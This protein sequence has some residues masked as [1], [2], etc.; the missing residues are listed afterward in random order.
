MKHHIVLVMELCE[1][2][3]D[4]LVKVEPFKE[5]EIIIISLHQLGKRGEK[6][7]DACVCII[8]LAV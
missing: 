5:D 6:E 3:L 4:H 2:D 8:I 7:R 1:Y